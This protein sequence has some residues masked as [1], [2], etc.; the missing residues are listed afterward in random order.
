MGTDPSNSVVDKELKVH[1]IENLR[2]IDGSVIPE[3]VSS[4]NPRA[5]TMAIAE[6]GAILI[7]ETH[8]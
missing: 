7:K 3:H 4:C 1:G 8:Q 6:K 5:V 2:I